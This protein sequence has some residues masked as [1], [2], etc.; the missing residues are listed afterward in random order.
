MICIFAF[1]V[2]AFLAIFSATYRPLAKEAF[3][4]VFRR[5]T[6]RPCETA[7]DQRIKAQIVGSI[8]KKSHRLAKF[9]F[10]YFEVLSWILV[11]LTIASLA[12]S[13]Y[14]GYNYYR[15]GNCY[16]PEST[17]FC[18]FTLLEGEQTSGVSANYTGELIYPTAG[19]DLVIGPSD[20]KVTIIEFG[21]YLCPYTREAE[22]TVKQVLAK[23]KD[24][25]QYV[26]RD[27]PLGEK[28]TGAFL[29]AEAAQCAKEQGKFWEMHNKLFE[30]PV[31]CGTAEADINTLKNISAQLGLDEKKFA[32]CL[33]SKKYESAILEDFDAGIKAKLT[34]TPTFFI[35]NHTIVGP[36]PLAAFEKVIDEQLAK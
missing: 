17:A 36:R 1:F 22:P 23:Y 33:D 11:I 15:Y 4:C 26:Y 14:G 34:G 24:R 10:K 27:F 9:T 35:N 6:L 20:A 8:M 2:F 13:V 28:H 25:I 19:N 31:A 21:C 18:P 16:G 5:I 30:M 7:L 12:Y 29:H 32:D 3:E